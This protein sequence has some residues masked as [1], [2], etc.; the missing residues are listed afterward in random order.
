MSKAALVARLLLGLAFAAHGTAYFLG[1]FDQ[2]PPPEGAAGEFSAGLQASGYF[3]VLL[4]LTELGC[5]LLL[6]TGYFVP[7]ALTILA[8]VVLNIVLFHLFLA[9]SGLPIPIVFV[10]LGVFLA[11]AYRSSFRGVLQARAKVG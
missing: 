5:G 1:L 10:L 4:N 6:L 9:P 2:V 3:M 8:P 7:L 11:Y